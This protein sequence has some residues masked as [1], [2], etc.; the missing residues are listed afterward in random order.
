MPFFEI[1]AYYNGTKYFTS[2]K[3]ALA[4]QLLIVNIANFIQ[5]ESEELAKKMV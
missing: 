5:N 2:I 1:N 3:N 4:I